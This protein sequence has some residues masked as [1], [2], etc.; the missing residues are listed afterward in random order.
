MCGFVSTKRWKF[1]C[2]LNAE[3][4]L[5]KLTSNT[6]SHLPEHIG[7][8]ATAEKTKNTAIVLTISTRTRAMSECKKCNG[9]GYFYESDRRTPTRCGCSRSRDAAGLRAPLSKDD[10]GMWRK[11][12]LDDGTVDESLIVWDDR[13]F[14]AIYFDGIKQLPVK[15]LEGKVRW[16]GPVFS[17]KD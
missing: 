1:G 13:G 3:R 4:H 16:E 9:D 17:N 15:E 6:N 12:W 8:G 7:A 14:T 10:C 11:V 5:K 2:T